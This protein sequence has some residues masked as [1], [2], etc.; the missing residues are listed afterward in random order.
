MKKQ[1]ENVANEVKVAKLS[2]RLGKKL[3]KIAT[4]NSEE[5]NN[6]QKLLHVSNLAETETYGLNRALKLYLEKAKGVLTKNQISVLTFQNV[7]AYI[8]SSEKY[9]GLPLFTFHQITLICNAVVK[10][11]DKATKVAARV[12]KQGGVMGKKAEKLGANTKALN[13]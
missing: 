12:E 9:K 7:C 10:E 13:A 2:T 8:N 6:F 1:M 5:A 11:N 4:F 3:E